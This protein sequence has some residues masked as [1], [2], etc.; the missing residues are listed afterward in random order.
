MRDLSKEINQHNVISNIEKQMASRINKLIKKEKKLIFKI[1]K[2]VNFKEPVL[3][4]IKADKHV[5]FFEGVQKGKFYADDSNGNEVEWDLN[6]NDL[7]D[8]EYGNRSFKGYILYERESRPYP[9]EPIIEA[10]LFEAVMIKIQTDLAK[11]KLKEKELNI[12]K[13]MPLVYILA[14]IIGGFILYKLAVPNPET[15]IQ[16]IQNVS[17]NISDIVQN[18]ITSL[19]RAALT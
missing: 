11:W 19:N 1:K 17:Q 18:N 13:W 3:F 7:L 10:K 14:L 15:T 12:K 16:M 4:F 6:P 9:K 2:T 5:E 8:F